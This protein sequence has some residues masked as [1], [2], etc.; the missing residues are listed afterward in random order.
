[1]RVTLIILTLIGLGFLLMVG[2]LYLNQRNLLYYPQPLDRAWEHIQENAAFEYTVERDGFV[3]KGW[4]INPDQDRLFVYYGG[5]A[6]EASLSIESYAR[7]SG[8]A[9][10]LMNYRG[11][12]ESEGKSTER[13]L[14]KDAIVILN[15]LKDRYTDITLIGR[16]LG[17]GVAVQ[18]ACEV[19]VTRLVLVTPYDSIRAVAQDL[20][21]F[22]PVSWLL[23]DP[24][25]SLSA[26]ERVDVPALFLVAEEDRVI[27][28]KHSKRLF[29]NWKG[30]REWVEVP[31]TDH[32]SISYDPVYWKSM[33][34]FID[35]TL[36]RKSP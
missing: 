16:S 34:A 6:E 25:D 14:V 2:Y 4:L 22:A 29:E 31:G 19:S 11:Y 13:D 10:L 18:V 26:S 1:M 23:K 17:S 28:M 5:N 20:Y 35:S 12:G 21:P 32:N 36:A 3:L 8:V 33:S 7:S 30:D 24:F 15:G 9:V 27:P